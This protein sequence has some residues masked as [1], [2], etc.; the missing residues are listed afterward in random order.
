MAYLF[1]FTDGQV[2]AAS[3][4]CNLEPDYFASRQFLKA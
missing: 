1:G 4:S 2:E 3:V